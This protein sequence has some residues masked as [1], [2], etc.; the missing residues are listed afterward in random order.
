LFALAWMAAVGAQHMVSN[1][2][3]WSALDV[4]GHGAAA[5]L[6]T[7]GLLPR[8]GARPVVC[9]ILAG[10]LIDLDH[11]VAAGSLDP[12]RMASLGARP[13]T[14]SLSTAVVLGLIGWWL[15]GRAIGYALAAGIVAHLLGDAIE[16][17]G[18]P[19]LFPIVSDPFVH[20]PLAALLTVTAV[21]AA[22]SVWLGRSQLVCASPAGVGPPNLPVWK[23]R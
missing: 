10:T 9:A 1:I 3:V 19:L 17:A 5:G 8:F 21:V 14:H 18:V 20:V 12:E 13:P 15:M 2:V 16:P 7:V 6:F 11:A 22:F 4:V 23:S